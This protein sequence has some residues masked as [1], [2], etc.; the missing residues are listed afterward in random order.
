M[1]RFKLH[2]KD[3]GIFVGEYATNAPSEVNNQT[4][5]ESATFELEFNEFG[6]LVVAS[7]DTYT[8]DAGEFE[9]W[10]HV[11]VRGTL[12]VNGELNCNEL[13]IDGGTINDNGTIT[14]GDGYVN[15]YA[16]LFD[17]D[18]FAGSYTPLETLGNKYPY[19]ERIDNSIDSLV[20]GIEPSTQLQNEYINGI[21]AILDNI[22]DSRNQPL[23]TNR[24]TID[25]TI[26]AQ[27][28]EYADHA[29]IENDLKL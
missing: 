1:T 11:I 10:D 15:N 12:T 24:I 4:R 21:W 14:I 29:A 22:T 3:N 9:G 25:V 27:Y 5:G 13:T 26:L 7:G 2:T 6:D 19:S 20:F 23:S 8:I 16:D 28:D 18:R 17:Y